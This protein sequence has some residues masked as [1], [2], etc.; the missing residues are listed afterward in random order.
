MLILI[1]LMWVSACKK[2]DT[3]AEPNTMLTGRWMVKTEKSKEYTNNVFTSES[4]DAFSNAYLEFQGD[5]TLLKKDEDETSTETYKYTYE[6][7]NNTITVLFTTGEQFVIFSVKAISKTSLTISWEETDTYN[8]KVYK[9][10]SEWYL[11]K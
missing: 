6:K 2:K 3:G 7:N 5:G 8:G 10:L 11:E 9:T 4:S 1:L